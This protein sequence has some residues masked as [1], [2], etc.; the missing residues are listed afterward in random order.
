MMTS[1][2][3]FPERRSGGG[4]TTPAG[5]PPPPSVLVRKRK[6]KGD[7][8]RPPACQ[9]GLSWRSLVEQLAPQALSPPV[10]TNNL[11][12][13]IGGT[14]STAGLGVASWRRG[15]QADNCLELEVVTGDGEI[16]RCSEGQ[17]RELFD[18]VR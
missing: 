4:G 11:D 17:N 6:K 18:S 10:L 12:V 16:V 7:L 14:L 9:A 1:P 15:T 3:F 5:T 8:P 13:T 2:P